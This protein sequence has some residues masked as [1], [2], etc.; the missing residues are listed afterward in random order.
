MIIFRSKPALVIHQVSRQWNEPMA[1]VYGISERNEKEKRQKGQDY[2]PWL[3]IE[4]DTV[5]ITAH[6]LT[7]VTNSVLQLKYLNPTIDWKRLEEHEDSMGEAKWLK[8]AR[9]YKITI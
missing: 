5:K 1:Y 8:T 3:G 7:C 2:C 6:I 4:G 9:H